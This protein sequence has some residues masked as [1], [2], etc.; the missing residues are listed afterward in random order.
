MTAPVEIKVGQIWHPKRGV[1]SAEVMAIKVVAGVKIIT[2]R[3]FT[4]SKETT[5]TMK[6]ATLRGDY[7]LAR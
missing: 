3:K 4:D 2:V 1:F 6:V 5:T 7:V